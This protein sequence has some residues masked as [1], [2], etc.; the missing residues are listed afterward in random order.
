MKALIPLLS[1]AVIAGLRSWAPVAFIA[2]RVVTKSSIV[3]CRA[4]KCSPAWPP[5][6][7]LK[8]RRRMSGAP[9]RRARAEA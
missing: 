2:V 5:S 8:S 6:V 9:R 1:V 7:V 3:R 4:T